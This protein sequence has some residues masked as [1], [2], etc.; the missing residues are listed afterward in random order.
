MAY[1]VVIAGGSLSGL[2]C[3]REVA[4][5]GHS[6][7]VLEED[8]EVGS[9]EH[10]GGLVS[11]RALN[12]LGIVPGI[13]TLDVRVRRADIHSPS[14]RRITVRVGSNGV[15]GVSRRDLD[16]QVACQAHRAGAD[17]RAGVR[18]A[19]LHDGAA[20]TPDG[21]IEAGV[22]VD[23]RGISSL[24]RRSRSGILPCA[25][26]MV[27]APWIGDGVEVYLDQERYPGF[28]AWV[29]PVSDGVGKVGAAGRGINAAEALD[30]FLAS[31]GRHSVTRRVYAPVWIGGPL[32]E[33]VSGGVVSVGDAAGQAKPTTAGG[34]YS[35]G[36]GG[37][38]AGRA[39]SEYLDTGDGACLGRYRE[40]WSR[41]F[42]AEFERQRLARRM[43]ER[44]DNGAIDRLFEGVRSGEIEEVSASADFDFH[45][46]SVIRIL[47]VRGAVGAAGAVLASEARRIRGMVS[48]K[49]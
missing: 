1:D 28:F 16:R 6:V 17:I 4:R 21:R 47:G 13:R 10:C 31:R 42:G 2:L 39:I 19:R 41:R 44:L 40:E 26:Y 27:H 32:K 25:Q 36:A 23:A 48:G 33:F 34:I 45:A 49:V 5:G 35:S 9:P 7:L 29:I 20:D 37:M 22:V 14:G 18:V 24:V 8:H 11:A 43:L 15:L 3:A 30:S 46:A 38:L 12:D